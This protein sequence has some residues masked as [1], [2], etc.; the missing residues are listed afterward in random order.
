MDR[1]R[2]PTAYYYKTPKTTHLRVGTFFF[3]ISVCL[4]KTGPRCDVGS[5]ASSGE[6]GLVT[7]GEFNVICGDR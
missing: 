6:S 1:N 5:F 2:E 3:S 4:E 7:M